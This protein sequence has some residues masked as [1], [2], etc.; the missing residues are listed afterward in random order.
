[1]GERCLFCSSRLLQRDVGG[2]EHVFDENA[3]SDGGVIDEH[4]GD[5]TNE[6]AVLYNGAAAHECG[7]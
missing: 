4:V 3:V 6:L 7:Q 2:R 1:M 5:G